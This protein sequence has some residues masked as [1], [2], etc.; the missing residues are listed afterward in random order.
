M[1]NFVNI[2]PLFRHKLFTVS[3]VFHNSKHHRQVS[4]RNSNSNQKSNSSRYYDVDDTLVDL[5]GL[6]FMICFI[7]FCLPIN[8]LIEKYVSLTVQISTDLYS[9]TFPELE[10][11]RY[12]EQRL[13]NSR[14]L[15][16]TTVSFP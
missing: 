2:L 13:D 10:D 11:H 16:Q 9:S 15:N 4:T 7:I 8:F 6:M 5:T 3:S 14:K 12:I 1:D